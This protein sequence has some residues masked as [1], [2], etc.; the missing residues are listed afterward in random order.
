[1]LKLAVK[2][3][4]IIILFYF[5]KPAEDDFLI[6]YST[7]ESFKLQNLFQNWKWSVALTVGGKYFDKM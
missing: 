5:S 7:K 3:E 6:D 4:K 1:M 2:A